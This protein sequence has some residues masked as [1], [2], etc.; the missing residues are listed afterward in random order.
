MFWK[1]KKSEYWAI[2]L[3]KIVDEEIAKSFMTKELIVTLVDKIERQTGL[4]ADNFAWNYAN[5]KNKKRLNSFLK[6]FDKENVISLCMVNFNHS[7]SDK[8]SLVRF[9][10]SNPML[11]YHNKKPIKSGL[12]IDIALKSIYVSQDF[13][14]EFARLLIATYGLDY[15][16]ITKF[17]ASIDLGTETKIMNRFFMT[18][19]KGDNSKDL[20][21][22]FHR[23]GILSG[24][25]KQLYPINYLNESHL[26]DTEFKEI[27]TTTGKTVKVND[28][29]TEWSLNEEE[30]LRLQNNQYIYAKS[31]ITNNMSFLETE[32]SKRFYEE[33]RI[34]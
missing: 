34:N 16:Y 20:A 3:T 31:I 10:F 23:T 1:K 25:I 22:F 30:F 32:Q 9:D 33:M 6:Y 7:E 26:S 14:K 11:D 28:R 19:T 4:K 17:P 29:I 12:S 24:Y 21:W 8:E 2:K 5:S 27:I 15:G 18:Y 13:I